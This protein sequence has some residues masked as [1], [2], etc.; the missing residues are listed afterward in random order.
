[1]ERGRSLVW[2]T[3]AVDMFAQ[4]NYK[5]S[6]RQAGFVATKADVA[7]CQ[8]YHDLQSNYHFQPVAIETLLFA[9]Y[10]NDLPQASNVTPTLFADDTLLTIACA[11]SANLQNGVN[12][13]ATNFWSCFFIFIF[14]RFLMFFGALSPKMT[15]VFR[16]VSRFSVF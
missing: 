5:D 14:W 12:H 4:G 6:A 13:W 2:D 10:V 15:L 11:N 16:S 9:L 3:T 8:K 1:M 7:K